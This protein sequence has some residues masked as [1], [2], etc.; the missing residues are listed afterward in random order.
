MPR[1]ILAVHGPHKICNSS[2]ALLI[3]KRMTTVDSRMLV[4]AT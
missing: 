1:M 2:M 3:Q 4:K